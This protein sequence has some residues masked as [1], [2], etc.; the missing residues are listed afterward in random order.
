M[1]ERY[2]S[3]VERDGRL[4]ILDDGTAWIVEGTCSRTSVFWQDAMRVLVG[5]SDSGQNAHL[6]TLTNLDTSPPEVVVAN[7]P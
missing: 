5:Y 1:A 6:F 4:I 3:A 7:R 2:I